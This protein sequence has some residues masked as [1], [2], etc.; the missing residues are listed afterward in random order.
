MRRN[1]V[2]VLAHDS[3]GN[4]NELG[5]SPVVKQ[6]IVAQIFIAA[7]AKETLTAGSRIS[8]HDALTDSE[9]GNPFARRDNIAGEFVSK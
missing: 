2:K 4:T 6:Q 8:R 3:F 1:L 7:M 5:V 9:I